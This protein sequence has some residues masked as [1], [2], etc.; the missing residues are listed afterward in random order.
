[1][2]HELEG[3]AQNVFTFSTSGNTRVKRSLRGVK[4]EKMTLKV[5][6][7]E[8]AVPLTEI[9][10]DSMTPFLRTVMDQITTIRVFNTNIINF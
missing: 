5:T 4:H 6:E 9:S 2:R 7:L 8:L 1:M 3:M 10:K